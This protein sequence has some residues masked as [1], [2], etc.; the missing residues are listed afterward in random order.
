MNN[1]AEQKDTAETSSSPH[2]HLAAL[3]DSQMPKS[4][5]SVSM[6]PIPLLKQ[7]CDAHNCALTE[8][9]ELDPFGQLANT[10]RFDLVVVADQLEYMSRHHGE[11]L[12]GLVRN[13]HSNAM[14]VLYQPAIAPNKLRWALSD[15]LGMGL[16]RQA[17][18]NDNSRQMSLYSYDLDNY[19]FTRS[20]NNARF[21]AN[22]ENWGKYW[23]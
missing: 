5:L 17:T 6:N 18:F 22:P 4:L 11:E 2:Q 16:R 20:W 14:L 7:W 3:L 19:N 21:W 12:L 13:L 15:F 23:W 1:T 10:Q 9:A 8:I